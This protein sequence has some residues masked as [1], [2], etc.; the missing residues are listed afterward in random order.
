MFC[1]TLSHVTLDSHRLE[2]EAN[3]DAFL[4]KVKPDQEALTAKLVEARK[5][6]NK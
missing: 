2:F 5:R 6:L 3:P 1:Y 4:E